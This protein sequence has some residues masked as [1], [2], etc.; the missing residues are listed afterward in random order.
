[1]SKSF[2]PFLSACACMGP[3]YEEVHCPCVMV[4]SGLERSAAWKEAHTPEALAADKKRRNE[5][6]DAI[7]SRRQRSIEQ[8]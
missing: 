3:L 8:N 4:S 2:N 5:A 1:M 6:F 7:F